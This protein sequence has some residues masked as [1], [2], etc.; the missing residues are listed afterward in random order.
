M[1]K[2]IVTTDDG[3]VISSY[4]DANDDIGNLNVHLQRAAFMNDIRVDVEMARTRE[5]RSEAD[6]KE[7]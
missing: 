5:G 7:R 3:T 6:G 1:A 2:I 4:A